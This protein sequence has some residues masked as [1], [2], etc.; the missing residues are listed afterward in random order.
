MV[1]EVETPKIPGMIKLWLM[2]YLPIRVVPERSKLM[3]A[4]SLGYVG[5]M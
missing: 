4:K 3:A 1:A 2:T 5:K